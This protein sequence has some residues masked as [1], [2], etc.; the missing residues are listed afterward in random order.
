MFFLS[1]GNKNRAKILP[2]FG[3]LLSLFFGM[4]FA[5]ALEIP[6][7]P[8]SYISDNTDILSEFVENQLIEELYLLEQDTSV[9]IGILT[10]HSLE[11]EN[12]EMYANEV[13]REWGI[14]QQDKDNG[15]LLF[16]VLEDKEVRIEVGYGLEGS[17]TDAVSSQIIRNIVIPAFRDG[18]YE[19]GVVDAVAQL[20]RA[21]RQE[22]ILDTIDQ[23]N[24][25]SPGFGDKIADYFSKPF[26]LFIFIFI[27]FA[28]LG[29]KRIQKLKRIPVITLLT[30]IFTLRT[31][32][33]VD[34]VIVPV[35]IAFILDVLLRKIN[36]SKIASN[37][38]FGSGRRGGF[39]GGGFGGSSGGG[40]GGGGFG[41]GSSGGG[42]ASGKW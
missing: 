25:Y 7:A 6:A 34:Q 39:G 35:I 28:L 37:T 2:V 17:V 21:V 3:I 33:Y 10:I 26:T 15:L 5:Y 31:Y 40:F 30:L 12:L 19:Q 24:I 23:E 42:G 27:L 36:F 11:G 22:G 8:E 29:E 41:G 9:E 14:G 1:E 18:N 4:R 13:F 32:S 38:S 16:I 20:D